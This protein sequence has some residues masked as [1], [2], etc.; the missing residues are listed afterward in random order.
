M[1]TISN[2][3]FPEEDMD[4]SYMPDDT[5]MISDSEVEVEV[6]DPLVEDIREQQTM[7]KM[8]QMSIRGILDD[9]P[10][11]D[12]EADVNYEFEESEESDNEEAD[13]EEHYDSN[14]VISRGV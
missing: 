7:K 4:E 5:E 8:G 12:E 6:D 3:E 13:F 10:N 1:A 14:L 9:D 11:Y 2:I